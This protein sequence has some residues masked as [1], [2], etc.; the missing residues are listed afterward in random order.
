MKNRMRIAVGALASVALVATGS[1]AAGIPTGSADGGA[2]G[3]WQTDGYG[4]IISVRGDRLQYFDSTAISC[5]PGVLAARRQPGTPD[6]FVADDGSRQLTLQSRGRDQASLR[7]AGAV[8]D[9]ELRRL[10]AL[11]EPCAHPNGVKDPQTVFDVFWTTFAENYPFF[12]AKG[13]DWTAVRDRYRP[14]IGPTTTDAELFGYLRDILATLGDAHTALRSDTEEFARPLRP[15]T[16]P[17]DGLPAYRAFDQRVRALIEQHDTQGPL[18]PWGNGIIGYADLPDDLGYLRLSAFDGYADGGYEANAA[19]LNRALDEIFT[20]SR[21]A[22]LRGLVLDVR[23]N[24][25]GYDALGLELAS[26]LTGNPYIAYT[27]QARNDPADPT[28]FARS[29]PS[30]V[31]PHDGPRYTGPIA[32]L[33][34]PLTI[35]AGETFTQAMTGR[36]PEPHRVGDATQGAFSDFLWRTLPNGWTFALPNERFDS[37]GTSFDLTGVPPQDAVTATLSDEELAVGRDSAFDKALEHLRGQR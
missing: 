3:V 7:Y 37:R 17:L 24:F 20:A 19:E 23:L 15:G 4:T 27:K 8:G 36:A 26:R 22:R 16:R 10:P 28:R 13:V 12:A 30:R 2:E 25:G 33:T 18:Q 6:S 11:P 14:K 9:I 35:S 5:S 29:E 21:T 1:A 32:M 31:T 34:S